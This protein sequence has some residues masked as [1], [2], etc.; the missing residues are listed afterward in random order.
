M[1]SAK[2]DISGFILLVRLGI[3]HFSNVIPD[4]IDWPSINTL[5][6]KHG[7][8]AVVLDGID[9]LPGNKRPPKDFYVAVDR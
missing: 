2:K 3:G 4:N 7:L 6:Y 1:T 8:S 9:C 5:A